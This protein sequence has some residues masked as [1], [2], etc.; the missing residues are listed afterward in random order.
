MNQVFVGG[1]YFHIYV[2]ILKIINRE[3]K[4]GKSLLILNDHV[5]GIELLIPSLKKSGYFDHVIQVPFV[6]LKQQM[7][8]EKSKLS[9][10]F[11]RNKFLIEYIDNNSSITEYDS[12]IRSAEVNLFYKL[13]LCPFYIIL[14][15]G[16]VTTI[17]MVE[18]GE[19][20]YFPKTGR[21][22]AFRRRYFWKTPIGEGFDP[23]V[24]EIE[25][26]QPHRLNER[27][28]HKGKLL[29]LKKMQST[30]NAEEKNKILSI[31]LNEQPIAVNS[32][33]NLLLIT[34]P[35][36]EDKYLTEA[37]KVDVY[38]RMLEMYGADHS[39]FLKA[40]PRDLT[41]YKGKLNYPFTEIP[42]AFPLEMLDLLDNIQ[43]KAGV[44]VSSSALHN[45]RCVENKIFTGNEFLNEFKEKTT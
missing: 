27:V 38:N 32:G 30:L 16:R 4:S 35:W 3:D 22:K 28:R 7:K 45:I 31:F 21:F 17:R 34:Q 2:S 37:A 26:Q 44:T 10:M 36:S 19:N 20:N 42:R 25:V 40:H 1:S 41:D 24:K 18:D 11:N 23:E 13:G 14:K 15:Y 12:F 5:P 8:R 9:R 29:E 39:I 6:A 43:F 33:N